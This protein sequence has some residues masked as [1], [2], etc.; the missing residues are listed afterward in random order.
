VKNA[1]ETAGMY[2]LFPSAP[3]KETS[4]EVSSGADPASGHPEFQLNSPSNHVWLAKLEGDEN[5]AGT[6]WI[7][8][9]IA[10]RGA[11]KAAAHPASVLDWPNWQYSPANVPTRTAFW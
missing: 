1:G 11:L 5:R 9:F 3:M 4:D 10:A 2:V 8:T 6:K 7:E